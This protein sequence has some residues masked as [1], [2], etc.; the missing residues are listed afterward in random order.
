[1]RL[2]SL[3]L[4]AGVL[5]G[6]TAA[7]SIARTPESFSP[8]MRQFDFTY[9]ARIKDLPVGSHV[10]R[11]WIPVARSD[12]HQYVSLLKIKSSVP[13]RL[14][15]EPE[16]RDRMLYAEIRNPRSSEAEFT[17]T[18]RVLRREY[19]KGDFQQL[20]RYND[21]PPRERADLKHYL[22]PNRLIPVTG[23]IKS[24]ADKI[25]AGKQG[26][27]EKAHAVYN[28]L[29]HTFRY[30][31][32]GTGWGRGDAVWACDAKHGN[33]TD[34]HSAFIGM[35]RAEDIPARFVIGFPLPDHL[36]Q[37]T[38]SGYHCW[39]E[40]YLSKVG[41]V[42]VDISEAWQ[43]QEKYAYFFGTVD[44]NRARFSAGRDITLVP[45]QAG[46]PLNY[47]VY[48]YV[49]VDGKAAGKVEKHFTFQNTP[50]AGPGDKQSASM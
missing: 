31:K 49:E 41:W 22:E 50:A 4:C 29:F 7:V 26:P 24:L 34:F 38:I 9:Q 46:P 12:A 23:T 33:C 21:D 6:L 30:D 8:K 14:T 48:P 36:A 35:M 39:A 45:R 44:A 32:S 3:P 11:I 47:F 13:A 20:L 18:Y 19:S 27:V 16:F 10:V 17:I 43:H 5:L 28:Y 37:G 25:T 42:P 1:M 15:H 40:F 2:K